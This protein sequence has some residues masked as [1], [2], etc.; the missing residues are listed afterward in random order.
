[1]LPDWNPAPKPETQKPEQQNHVFHVKI[2]CSF[3][4]NLLGHFRVET[5]GPFF[6]LEVEPC[7]ECI[8]GMHINQQITRVKE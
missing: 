7:S 1:M 8:V 3:C 2:K 4:G 6:E 5:G